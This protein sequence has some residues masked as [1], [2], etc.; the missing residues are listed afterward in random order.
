MLI[1][2]GQNEVPPSPRALNP[3]LRS[4]PSLFHWTKESGLCELMNS[5]PIKAPGEP[6]HEGRGEFILLIEDERITLLQLERMLTRFN[7]Q[8]L[9]AASVAEALI[10]WNRHRHAIQAVVADFDLGHTRDGL[11]LLREFS[12]QKPQLVMLMATG[13]LTPNI[14]HD[15][16]QTANI[17][18]LGKPFD[19]FELLAKLRVGLDELPRR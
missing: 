7:Y 11:S 16:E 9:M 6:N 18:C 15:V 2:D 17:R 5:A 14:I 13:T 10:I 1:L 4:V 3:R 12:G 8:V 19:P